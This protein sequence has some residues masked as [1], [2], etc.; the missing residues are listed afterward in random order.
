[1]LILLLLLLLPVQLLI[2]RM[3]SRITCNRHQNPA[4]LN[5]SASSCLISKRSVIKYNREVPAVCVY[6]F[7]PSERQWWV[8][9]ALQPYGPFAINLVGV[10]PSSLPHWCKADARAR[11]CEPHKN[12]CHELW[13]FFIFLF[14]ESYFLNVCFFRDTILLGW[15]ISSCR[16]FHIF[17]NN[18]VKIPYWKYGK[19]DMNL[20][21]D[22]ILFH[23][24]LPSSSIK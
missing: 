24:F 22:L 18:L 21:T 20:C 13:F 11:K 23:F 4:C 5:L 10:S 17:S 7:L 15:C 1:M 14:Y 19:I 2:T 3:N 8:P 12:T 6:T 16:F 9:L